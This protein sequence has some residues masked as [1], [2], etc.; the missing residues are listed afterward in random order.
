VGCF[1]LLSFAY[2]F[3]IIGI[4]QHSNKPLLDKTPFHNRQ[5]PLSTP[6]PQ[7]FKIAK[8]GLEDNIDYLNAPGPGTTILR[9]SSTRKSLRGRTSGEGSSE[10]ALKALLFQ[11]PVNQGHHWDV[12]DI[13]IE[14]P[15]E[16]ELKEETIQDDYDEIEY[17]PP[18]GPGTAYLFS[19]VPVC[20]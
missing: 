16:N 2:Y 17:M 8:L 13:S 15:N 1:S 11:T 19:L 9:P 20:T 5:N 3:T 14:V 6:A 12:S 10:K 4:E 18:K 7:T